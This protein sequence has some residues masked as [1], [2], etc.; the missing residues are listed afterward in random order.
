MDRNST[1]H[2]YFGRKPLGTEIPLYVQCTS[3]AGAPTAPDA[4]PTMKIYAQGGGSP[5][6]SKSLPPLERYT[7]TG[8]FRYMQMLTSA[9]SAGLYYVRFDYQTSGTAK[10]AQGTFEVTA[11]G[12][13]NGMV[14]SAFFLDRP[15]SGQD[16]ILFTTD[17]GQVSLNRGPNV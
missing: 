4:A 14:N 1:F 9:F 16:W 17:G 10:S 13:A 2:E 11:G 12:D 5:V 8:L 15:G 6:V 7:A 3:T